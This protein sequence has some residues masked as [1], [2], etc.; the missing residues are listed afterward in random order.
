MEM[1]AL[2]IEF[3]IS[4]II[5]ASPEE[6]YTA[7]LDSATHTNMTG[8]LAEVSANVGETFEAWDGYIQGEN[9]E[10][11]YPSRILQHWRTTEFDETEKDSRLEI[12][13]EPVGEGTK[14]TL[15]HTA[16]PEHGMQYQQGWIDAY[17]IPMKGYFSGK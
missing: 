8:G 15:R 4:D 17:F 2:S 14:V 10:L 1:L 9:L 3:E 5:P 7:W 11:A 6:I 16:L 13:L 12:L